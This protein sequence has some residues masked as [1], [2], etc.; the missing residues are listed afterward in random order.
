MN[1]DAE[2]IKEIRQKLEKELPAIL[3]KL[4]PDKPA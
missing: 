2:T 1:K 4:L 3:K